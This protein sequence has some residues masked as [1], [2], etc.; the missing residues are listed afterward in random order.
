ML[1]NKDRR[2]LELSGKIEACRKVVEMTK[3]KGWQEIVEPLLNAMIEDVTGRKKDG[4]W[5]K[6]SI[7]Q[8][9][10][11]RCLGKQDALVTLYNKIADYTE[12]IESLEKYYKALDNEKKTYTTPM[13]RSAYRKKE[14]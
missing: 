7:Y 2:K 14:E 1:D 6:G 13:Q 10:V 8:E 3:T 4:R 5:I 12:G 9:D 11:S